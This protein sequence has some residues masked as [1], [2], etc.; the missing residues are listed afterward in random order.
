MRNIVREEDILEILEKSEMQ[1]ATVYDKC[2]IVTVKLPNGFV[3]TESSACVDP[4]NYEGELGINS[5]LMKITDKLW[6]LEGYR[7]Q[8]ELAERANER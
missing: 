3:L 1:V 4:K 2:T 8:C 7:L 6:E 5:C